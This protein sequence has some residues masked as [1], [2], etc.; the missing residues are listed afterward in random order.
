MNLITC[1]CLFNSIS[2]W[3]L[4][5]A[6]WLFSRSK[7]ALDPLKS[8]S[9]PQNSIIS[10]ELVSIYCRLSYIWISTR[11]TILRKCSL[12]S[13]YRYGLQFQ[14]NNNLHLLLWIFIRRRYQETLLSIQ[15]LVV[16]ISGVFPTMPRVVFE[17]LQNYLMGLT[18]THTPIIH[19]CVVTCQADFE[20][21][22]GI[23][24]V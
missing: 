6:F 12:S 5:V 23:C 15:V 22:F 16:N 7:P 4:A 9:M 10:S 3:L 2:D 20:S 1:R 21:L 17:V 14:I 24:D 18:T 11:D 13:N 8:S 19:L